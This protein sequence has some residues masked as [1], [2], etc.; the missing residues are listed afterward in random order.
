MYTPFLLSP[1]LCLFLFLVMEWLLFITLSRDRAKQRV[2]LFF[3]QNDFFYL[4][5][6]YCKTKEQQRIPEMFCRDCKF[7]F[8]LTKS[9][10]RKSHA[11]QILH[12]IVVDC[13]YSNFLRVTTHVVTYLFLWNNSELITPV[14]QTTNCIVNY[15]LAFENLCYF[16]TETVMITN[17]S[18]N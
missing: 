6:I 18:L 3:I 12:F 13:M 11:F 4:F 16:Q 15:K 14:T 9:M 8:L 10:A 1:S 7:F 2:Y 17:L 5:G